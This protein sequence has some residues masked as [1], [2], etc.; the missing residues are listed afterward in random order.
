M[1]LKPLLSFILG[2]TAGQY[3]Q[4]LLDHVKQLN[5]TVLTNDEKRK[6]AYNSLKADFTAG[7][8]KNVRDSMINLAVEAAVV[9]LSK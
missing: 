3:K 5:A 4:K 2:L 1:F 7:G 8:A 6:A 9:Y